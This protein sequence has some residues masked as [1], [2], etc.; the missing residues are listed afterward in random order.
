VA[1]YHIIV[2]QQ[3]NE[4]FKDIAV[5]ALVFKSRDTAESLACSLSSL[6]REY[7]LGGIVSWNRLHASSVGYFRALL[8]AFL[9]ADVR[10]FCTITQNYSFP[11]K[12]RCVSVYGLYKETVAYCLQPGDVSTLYLDQRFEEYPCEGMGCRLAYIADSPCPAGKSGSFPLEE[13]VLRMCDLEKVIE[14]ELSPHAYASVEFA[15]EGMQQQLMP[16][17]DVL[18]GATFYALEETSGSVAKTE[19]ADLLI[20]AAG[21]LELADAFG[22]QNEGGKVE[23]HGLGADLSAQDG[24]STGED[25]RPLQDGGLLDDVVTWDPENLP[26]GEKL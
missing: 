16:L 8:E 22:G 25:D 4:T 9:A 21:D 3:T 14:H 18:L 20:Q 7:P 23:V 17:L 5:G 26:L 15:D 13:A 1:E 10:F 6:E 24:A 11:S 19:I 12:G 2:N